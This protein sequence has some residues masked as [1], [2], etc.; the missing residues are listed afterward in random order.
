MTTEKESLYIDLQ[1]RKGETNNLYEGGY[2]TFTLAFENPFYNQ[3]VEKQ[4]QLQAHRQT[5]DVLRSSLKGKKKK[6]RNSLLKQEEVELALLKEV[7]TIAN[8]L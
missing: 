7:E 3:L 5:T 4:A 1:R 8:Q 2:G 6:Q